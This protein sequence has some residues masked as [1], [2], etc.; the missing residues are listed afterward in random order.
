MAIAVPPPCPRRES[1]GPV[2]EGFDA[3]TWLI[4]LAVWT[5]LAMLFLSTQPALA[6]FVGVILRFFSPST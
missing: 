3:K 5:S 1:P 6:R 4:G 2:E